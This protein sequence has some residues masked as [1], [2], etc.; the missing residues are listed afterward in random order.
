MAEATELRQH[1]RFREIEGTGTTTSDPITNSLVA[2]AENLRGRE[3]NT[4]QFWTSCSAN[5]AI[6]S[7]LSLAINTAAQSIPSHVQNLAVMLVWSSRLV[8]LRA[9][10]RPIERTSRSEAI[11]LPWDINTE[12]FRDQFYSQVSYEL[13]LEPVEDGISHA[14]ERVMQELLRKSSRVGSDWINTSFQRLIEEKKEAAA[15]GLLQCIGRI[16]SNALND[17]VSGLVSQGLAH[18][19]AQVRE[20]A[21]SVVEQIG[22]T[23]L[24][25]LLRSHSDPVPWLNRYAEQVLRDLT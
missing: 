22:D 13:A 17:I 11:I 19:S 10:I 8:Q 16:K 4:L 9:N 18:S 23:D 20:A 24:T 14:I 21:I 5:T 2:G 6:R 3:D 7:D 1:R 15:A 25:S 12:D